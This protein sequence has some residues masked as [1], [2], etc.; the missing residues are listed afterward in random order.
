MDREQLLAVSVKNS[1]SGLHQCQAVTPVLE[2]WG[3]KPHILGFGFDTTADNTGKDKGLIV[4]LEKVI[5]DACWWCACPH[6][7]YELHV[8]KIARLTYGES[9]SPDEQVYKKFQGHWNDLLEK[10]IDYTKLELFN[11]KKV[12]GTFLEEQARIVLNFCKTCLDSNVFP[13]D[14]YKELCTLAVVW[15]AGPAKV[16]G[17]IFQ[18]PGAF[19][20]ARFMMQSIY[21][22]K[23][24]LLSKQV[25]ILSKKE[26]GQVSVMAEFV[27]LFHTL[28]FLKC[29]MTSSAPFL[30][31]QSIMQMKRY[32]KHRPAISDL[33]LNSMK[34][35]L[36]HITEQSVITA[37]AD[38]NLSADQRK[39]LALALYN[40]PRADK[41][42]PEQPKFPDVFDEKHYPNKLWL[43]GQVPQLQDFVG[44]RSWLIF[45]K[46]QLGQVDCEWLQLEPTSWSLMSGYQRFRKFVTETTIVNDPAER[47]VALAADFR[48]SFQQ[49]SV[50]QSN[51]VTVA[52]SR[53]LVPRGSK[54]SVKAESIKKICGI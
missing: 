53:K 5:G 18:Y 26:K 6:H 27:G 1:N 10:G 39:S 25:T 22:L 42:Q 41:F 38:E 43:S 31:L 3:V 24:R 50:C 49:E 11:W 15:L 47:G 44:P 23:M 7:H 48:S 46:L 12:T 2:D 52:E 14:D 51:L 21:S 4:R 19:H 17:F 20:H 16:D 28:W 54:Q 36:W 35:H 30:Q 29:P 32:R 34:N 37:L 45:N 9:T 8:K 40:T 33:V 13:R